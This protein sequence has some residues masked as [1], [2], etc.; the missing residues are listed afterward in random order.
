MFSPG[1]EGYGFRGN[2]FDVLERSLPSSPASSVL[3]GWG[4]DER[5]V[6]AQWEKEDSGEEAE[7]ASEV[8]SHLRRRKGGNR[9]TAMGAGAQEQSSSACACGAGGCGGGSGCEGGGC[10]EGCGSVARNSRVSWVGGGGGAAGF[11]RVRQ[12]RKGEEEGRRLH[13]TLPYMR[14]ELIRHAALDDEDAVDEPQT[15]SDN[16][17]GTLGKQS[18][19]VW[20]EARELAYPALLVSL[21]VLFGTLLLAS[22]AISNPEA[23]S[24]FASMLAFSPVWV[25]RMLCT[26]CMP[27][28]RLFCAEWPWAQGFRSVLEQ[29]AGRLAPTLSPF[30]WSGVVGGD[31]RRSLFKACFRGEPPCHAVS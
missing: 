5:G 22:V 23:H 15:S 16:V 8:V 25:K 17:D 24:L 13:G 26:H 6:A 21:F 19:G 11:R 20:G 27:P 31:S 30:S 29:A 3:G 10:G 28:I 18:R 1:L 14:D 12:A 2:T 9:G 7:E 4:G